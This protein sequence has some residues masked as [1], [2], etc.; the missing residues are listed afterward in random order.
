MFFVFKDSMCAGI[1]YWITY[2][3]VQ[4][5]FQIIALCSTEHLAFKT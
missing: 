2:L 4:K 5:L 1:H 3:Q